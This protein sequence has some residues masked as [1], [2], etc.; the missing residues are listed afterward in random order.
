MKLIE[1]SM[2]NFM[3]YRERQEIRF[4][5][6]SSRNV[7]IVFGDNM[8]GKT[9]FLNAIRWAFYGKA[10]GRHL[11]PIP[12]CN[13]VNTD[14]AEAGDWT[15]EVNVLF[16]A[17]GNQ[18]DLRRRMQKRELVSDPKTD[19]DFKIDLALRIDGTPIE[20]ELICHEINQ[21]I[22][23]QISRFF[24]FDAELLQEYEMLLIQ[25]NEQGYLIK[26]EIEK[27]LGVPALINGRDE[28]QTLLKKARKRQLNETKHIEG[29]KSLAG[30]Q[31]RLQ[32][33][34]SGYEA[35]LKRLQSRLEEKKKEIDDL[36]EALEATE[37][38]Y[39]IKLKIDFNVER[40]KSLE[41]QEENLR[42]ER[43]DLL[44]IAWKDL[45]QA[46]LNVHIKHLESFQDKYRSEIGMAA[47]LES[48]IDELKT[49]IE[50]SVCPTCEQEILDKKREQFGESLGTLEAEL[51]AFDID[52][53]KFSTISGEI[54]RLR[55]IRSSGSRERIKLIESELIRIDVELNKCESENEEF[56]EKIKGFDTAEMARMRTLKEGYLSNLGGL[57]KDADGVG[58]KIEENNAKQNQLAKLISQN[59]EARSQKGSYL[60]D[61]YEALAEIFSDGV[62]ALRDSLKES[63]AELSSQAFRKLTTEETYTDLAI[64]E[65]YGLTIID[66]KGR[67]VIERSSGAE[68]IVALSL[69]DGLN[70][71]ARKTGPIIID[72]PLSRLDLKHRDN[73]LKYLPQMTEQL[74]LLVHEGEIQREEITELLHKRLG[75]CVEIERISSSQSRIK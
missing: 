27:A 3:P 18:Y 17:N 12:Y 32:A 29:L 4:P 71:T 64:N 65:N 20:H 44:Q 23:E 49:L 19:N 59:P 69:I 11:R 26:E 47:K 5:T 36:D 9:S 48:K 33:D 72:T 75:H 42:I 16:D 6:D 70:R 74:V 25:G 57:K 21:I 7:M 40:I 50:T 39:K 55:K 13:I 34:L 52:T 8:R 68:Q 35:D 53:E 43:R 22:P 30:Q 45:L 51:E 28:L 2:Q 31:A 1:L 54:S 38:T 58:E 15:T 14:S 62:D 63:V 24:L 61:K 60:V 41:K 46:R 66:K 67:P 73:V 37:G 56:R 10:L